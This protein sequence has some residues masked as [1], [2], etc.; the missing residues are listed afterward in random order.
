MKE[1]IGKWVRKKDSTIIYYILNIIGNEVICISKL[2]IWS[3]NIVLLIKSK[4]YFDNIIE[5]HDVG[6]D[7]YNDINKHVVIKLIF[8][9]TEFISG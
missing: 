1:Y 5:V 9:N 7:G 3:T 4:R 2:N 6:N 8:T